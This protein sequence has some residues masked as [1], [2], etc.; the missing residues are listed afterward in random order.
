MTAITVPTL[1]PAPIT[2]VEFL[3]GSHFQLNENPSVTQSCQKSM[4]KTHYIPFSGYLKPAIIP[5]PKPADIFHPEN[6]IY[7]RISETSQ[8]YSERHDATNAAVPASS[9]FATHF[10]MHS[11]PSLRKVSSSYNVDYTAP[12]LALGMTGNKLGSFIYKSSLSCGDRK[13]VRWPLS[14]YRSSYPGYD[15]MTHPVQKAPSMHLG[16]APTIK[17][18]IQHLSG[19]ITTHKA[20]F[21]DRRPIERPPTIPKYVSSKVIGG[22]PENVNEKMTEQKDSYTQQ[23]V[24]NHK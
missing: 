23:D 14:S 7:E 24:R 1:I 8:A 13:N 21:Y 17:G 4:M 20:E 5:P 10:K 15:K 18:D 9:F 19:T 3:K 6:K 16:G 2:G 11:D 22:D 12:G